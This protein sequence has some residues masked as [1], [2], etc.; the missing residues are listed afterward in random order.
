MASRGGQGRPAGGIARE[1][2]LG[3]RGADSAPEGPF[4][5]AGVG[6]VKCQGGLAHFQR[7]MLQRLK[8]SKCFYGPCV[9]S[10]G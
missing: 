5:G 3:R 6:I 1:A 10:D 4:E 7:G 9:G 2:P 8:V